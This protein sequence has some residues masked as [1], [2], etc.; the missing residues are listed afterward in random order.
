MVHRAAHIIDLAS[1]AR[2]CLLP[3]LADALF[4]NACDL[5]DALVAHRDFKS[6]NG[7]PSGWPQILNPPHVTHHNS[8]TQSGN[9]YAYRHPTEVRPREPK[10]HFDGL[11]LE[12]AG[13][14]I[15]VYVGM[16]REQWARFEQW[17]REQRMTP[18]KT[19]E[20]K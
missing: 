19:E 20:G 11:Q 16:T 10:A 12:H 3:D 14:V 13:G 15:R 9:A 17:E 2:A 7:C 8:C 4:T 18:A 5:R 6:C 1:R